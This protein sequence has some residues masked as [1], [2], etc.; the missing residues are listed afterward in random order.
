MV[1]VQIAQNYTNESFSS[2]EKQTMSFLFPLSAREYTWRDCYIDFSQYLNFID[3]QYLQT[4]Q[5]EKKNASESSKIDYFPVSLLVI[6]ALQCVI[7]DG[8]IHM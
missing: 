1:V 2:T 4:I 8:S 3:S 6:S 7:E 5:G